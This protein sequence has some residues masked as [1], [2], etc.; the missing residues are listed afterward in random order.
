MTD[1]ELFDHFKTQSISLNEMPGNDLWAKIESRIENPKSTFK[2]HTLLFIILGI[3]TIAVITFYLLF[4][5]DKTITNP[6]TSPAIKHSVVEPVRESITIEQ[7]LATPIK[8]KNV[9]VNEKAEEIHIPIINSE[10]TDSV[11]KIQIRTGKVMSTSA[12]TTKPAF[13][14]LKKTNGS[15]SKAQP[16]STYE[17]IKKETPGNIIVTTKEK[18]T[19][20]EYNQLIQDMLNEYKNHTQ[21]LLTIKAPGQK[22]FKRV[23]GNNQ[24]L[25]LEDSSNLIKLNAVKTSLQAE[26]PKLNISQEKLEIIPFM[27]I[28]V[29]NDS[30][31]K[32]REKPSN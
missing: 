13:M 9:V 11:K 15:L 3:T 8:D 7:P 28:A 6:A 16:S 30:L 17:V 29:K 14:P 22:T 31:S 32:T 24:K 10:K 5:T 12:P 18:I 19:N 25:T 2:P 1:N 21:T 20:D 26:S 23:I 27:T 4:P